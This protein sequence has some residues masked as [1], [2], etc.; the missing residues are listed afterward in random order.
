[1]LECSFISPGAIILAPKFS[2]NSTFEDKLDGSLVHYKFFI[3][4]RVFV[5]DFQ[6]RDHMPFHAHEMIILFYYNVLIFPLIRSLDLKRNHLP[7]FGPQL[8]DL[9]LA[10]WTALDELAPEIPDRGFGNSHLLSSFL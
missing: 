7:L 6:I 9:I 3:Q 1:M 10:Q 2:Q 5:H 4:I 8:P